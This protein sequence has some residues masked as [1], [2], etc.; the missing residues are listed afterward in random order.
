MAAIGPVSLKIDPDG[1]GASE[2]TVEYTI[3]FSSLD[4][5]G[6]VEYRERVRLIGDDPLFDDDL[7]TLQ[8]VLVSPNSLPTLNRSI[9]TQVAN[10]TLNEDIGRDEI[11]A[12][13]HLRDVARQFPPVSR[14]SNTVTG[15]F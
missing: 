13:V 4:V 8:N 3:T 11:F 12:R 7:I 9:V 1:S 15:N 6:N 2:V 10:S 5:L 14:D